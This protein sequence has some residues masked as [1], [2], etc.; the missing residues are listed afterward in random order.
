MQRKADFHFFFQITYQTKYDAFK[1]KSGY[2]IVE[3]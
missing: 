2:C 1:L 3:S